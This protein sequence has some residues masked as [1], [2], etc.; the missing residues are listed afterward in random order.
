MWLQ[1]YIH[2]QHI[3]NLAIFKVCCNIELIPGQHKLLK[4]N[5][6]LTNDVV[7]VA[8]GVVGGGGGGGASA[9]TVDVATGAAVTAD[10]DDAV[11]AVVP[12]SLTKD[13][14]AYVGALVAFEGACIGAFAD[15]ASKS[16]AASVLLPLR[17]RRPAVRRRRASRCRH[18]R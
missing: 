1:C 6:S 9:T 3:F 7:D 16:T 12:P 4:I 17:C 5:F 18:R 11:G 8:I 10:D 2:E 13:K 14:D 15:S